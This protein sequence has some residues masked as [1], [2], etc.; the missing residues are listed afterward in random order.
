LLEPGMPSGGCV[1]TTGWENDSLQTR[2]GKLPSF[3]L[4]VVL[5]WESRRG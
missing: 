5:V 2:E 1:A 3:S 4:V